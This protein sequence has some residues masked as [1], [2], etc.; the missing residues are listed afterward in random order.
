MIKKCF[1]KNLT[2]FCFCMLYLF[3]YSSLYG[4]IDTIYSLG[5]LNMRLTSE[6]LNQ[7]I[8]RTSNSMKNDTI[9]WVVRFKASHEEMKEDTVVLHGG[10]HIIA[11][12]LLS[13]DDKKMV[14]LNKEMPEFNFSTL[15]GEEI[16]SENLKGKVVLFNFWFTRCPP[17][18]V[19]MPY[20]NVIKED[21]KDK[22]IEF[23]SMAPEYAEQ[24]QEFL[25]RYDFS[26]KH[27]ADADD[28]LKKF[29]VGFPKNILVDKSGVVKYIGGAIVDGLI[30]EGEHIEEHQ[31]AWDELRWMID[32]LLGLNH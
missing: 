9:D 21:Y 32:E 15:T 18:I 22:D 6:E 4:Q 7:R 11:Q 30:E 26:F 17:C 28:F 2:T 16:S 5:T 1:M 20:L 23:I 29:G 13:E 19:E 24:V 10:L 3:V 27:I 14:R 8:E 31:L 25:K 12:S